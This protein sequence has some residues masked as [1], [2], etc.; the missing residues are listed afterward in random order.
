MTQQDISWFPDAD[1]STQGEQPLDQLGPDVGTN[2]TLIT[3]I[4]ATNKD[5]ARPQIVNFRC[6]NHP[7]LPVI[8]QKADVYDNEKVFV[9]FLQQP[10]LEKIRMAVFEVEVVGIQHTPL[11]F[12]WVGPSTVEA[13]EYV[14]KRFPPNLSGS[15]EDEDYNDYGKKRAPLSFLLS[16]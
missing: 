14:R 8:I 2:G 11:K 12:I 15:E 9:P 10:S 5:F 7:H 16:S 3:I 1:E 6:Q 4:F 13:L